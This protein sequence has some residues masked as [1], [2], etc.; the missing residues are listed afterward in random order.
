MT[1]TRKTQEAWKRGHGEYQGLKRQ[2]AE[3]CRA[4]LGKVGL[5]MEPGVTIKRSGKV[6]V[7]GALSYHKE[8]FTL[9]LGG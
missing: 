7:F 2:A 5:L 3:V 6:Q 4:L 1:E 9:H 8:F